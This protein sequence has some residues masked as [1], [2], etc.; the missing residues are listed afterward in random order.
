MESE[1]EG[2]LIALRPIGAGE[3]L[4]AIEGVTTE[5]P[6]RHTLQI[7][8]QLHLD[9][10]DGH[11]EEELRAR[12]GW[13]FVEH[14]CEPNARI[15][16][17]ELVALRAIAPGEAITYDYNTTEWEL[18]APFRCRCGS[19]KCL[20][21]I[22]GFKHLTTEQRAALRDVALHLARLAG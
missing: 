21:E 7:D 20:G 22:R 15:V 9:A 12:F 8:E 5:R 1:G 3:R 11:S 19:T 13:R 18:A 4:C 14:G 2:R 6:G 10:G 17:R 16:R